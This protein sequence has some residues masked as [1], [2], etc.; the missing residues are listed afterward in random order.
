MKKKVIGEGNVFLQKFRNKSVIDANEGNV[1]KIERNGDVALADA[2]YEEAMS[3]YVV[4]IICNANFFIRNPLQPQYRNNVG[5]IAVKIG[6]LKDV[7]HVPIVNNNKLETV[8]LLMTY[9]FVEKNEEDQKER[10][11]L[12]SLIIDSIK[13]MKIIPTKETIELNVQKAIRTGKNVLDPITV[14]KNEFVILENLLKASYKLAVDIDPKNE[15]IFG[16]ITM[17]NIKTENNRVFLIMMANI[18]LS[19]G[20]YA[21]AYTLLKNVLTTESAPNSKREIH[22]TLGKVIPKFID[23]I[24]E[25]ATDHLS[26]FNKY[27]NAIPLLSEAIG[28][29][30]EL[31]N[32]ERK[33]KKG[34]DGQSGFQDLWSQSIFDN[35]YKAAEAAESQS[36]SDEEKGLNKAIDLLTLSRKCS[37]KSTELIKSQVKL[38]DVYSKMG[39]ANKQ[40]AIDSFISAIHQVRMEQSISNPFL[41]IELYLKLFEL[42]IKQATQPI[43]DNY[44]KSNGIPKPKVKPVTQQ[45]VFLA[46]V[47]ELNTTQTNDQ[48]K[49]T[50]R[51]VL[52]KVG[53]LLNESKLYLEAMTLLTSANALFHNSA[54]VT[55]RYALAKLAWFDA[56]NAQEVRSNNPAFQEI[57]KIVSLAISLYQKENNQSDESRCQTLLEKLND[58]IILK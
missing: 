39:E 38:G 56:N 12:L 48:G 33:L 20:E 2:R 25:E 7:Y 5:R 22:E 34:K 17:M 21:K 1:E 37:V 40:K 36:G 11:I 55:E 58:R 43:T 42:D 26:D 4:S 24:C 32:V 31:M 53:T 23:K 16:S 45:H 30:E 50:L 29:I 28:L 14:I 51:D 19:K 13:K 35:L 46:E 3:L 9:H 54:L 10:Q 57:K 44:L 18:F 41:I 27:M 52:L 8:T 47:E 49:I 6:D 15:E